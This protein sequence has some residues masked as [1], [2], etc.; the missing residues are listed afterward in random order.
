[1]LFLSLLRIW[2]PFDSVTDAIGNCNGGMTE[3]RSIDCSYELTDDEY[4]ELPGSIVGKVCVLLVT[5]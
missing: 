2:D 1:M 5:N 3:A 4:I